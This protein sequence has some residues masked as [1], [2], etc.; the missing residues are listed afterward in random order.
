MSY[1]NDLA[2]SLFGAMVT[3]RMDVVAYGPRTV[4]LD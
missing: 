3:G 2:C 1:L 4:L